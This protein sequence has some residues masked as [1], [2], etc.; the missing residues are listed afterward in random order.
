MTD[1]LKDEH[2]NDR[3]KLAGHYLTASGCSGP[4]SPFALPLIDCPLLAHTE[5][6]SGSV[7]M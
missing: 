7:S 1:V 6:I 3:Q 2:A 4:E 5:E